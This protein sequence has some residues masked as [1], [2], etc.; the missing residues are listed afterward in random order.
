MNVPHRTHGVRRRGL[1]SGL[2][3]LL[4]L[5]LAL[6]GACTDDDPT[7]PN[8]DGTGTLSV[9]ITDAPTDVLESATVIVDSVVAIPA[10]GPPVTLETELDEVNL[11]ELTDGVSALLA[12]EEVAAGT[13]V[14]LRLMVSEATVQLEDGWTFRDGT[15]EKTLQVPSGAQTGIKLVLGGG[16]GETVENGGATSLVVDFD[17]DRSFVL[18][19]N[20]DTPAGLQGVLFKPVVRV[21]N[22]AEGGASISGS[23]TA[24]E[25]VS[26]EGLEVEAEPVED[27]GGASGAV[28]SA[29]EGEDDEGEVEDD[30]EEEEEEEEGQTEDAE[31][32]TKEDGSYTI[33]FLEPGSYEVEVEAPE[34]WTAEPSEQVVE[35]GEDEEVTEIDFE[36]V[37]ETAGDEGGEEASGSGA[38]GTYTVLLTDAPT[39]YLSSAVVTFGSVELIP[40]DGPPVVLAEE[41]GSFDLLDLQG[42]V[43]A[44]L[45]TGAAEAGE[46]RQLRL[47]IES[48]EVTLAEGYEFRDGGTTKSLKVPSG[49]QTGL[50][51]LLT[52]G[53]DDGGDEVEDGEASSEEGSG[54]ETGTVEQGGETTAVVDFDVSR[55]FAIQGNPET[56]AGIKG[57]LLKPV[58]RISGA[59]TAASITGTVVPGEGV[60]DAGLLE[61]LEVTATPATSTTEGEGEQTDVATAATDADGAYGLHFLAPGTYVVAVTPPEGHAVEPTEQEVTVE[62]GE[63][64][65]GVDFTLVSSTGTESGGESGGDDGSSGDG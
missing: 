50:K 37:E 56:P 45:A 18:Q 6:T 25:G 15:T 57:V 61:G 21:V 40:T 29:Q 53:D 14:Q 32:R 12:Q 27:E 11:L 22:G 4:V 30:E 46:Y 13:Y 3:G 65:T 47:R 41:A 64:A 9:L 33:H 43:T 48:A 54:G 51:L 34:G 49:A 2:A 36:L 24:P 38:V 5:F 55:S 62:E 7:G 52:N 60:E 63:D 16:D 42:E 35:V 28:V 20:P 19:G 23:V 39:D 10:D 8:A 59:G 31:T 26:V 58:L 17:A 44:L 1:A